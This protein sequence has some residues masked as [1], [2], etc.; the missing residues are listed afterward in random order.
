MEN[1]LEEMVVNVTVNY[2]KYFNN[3]HR[4]MIYSNGVFYSAIKEK[5]L[6]M[7]IWIGEEIIKNKIK[8]GEVDSEYYGL[9]IV[10]KNDDCIRLIQDHYDGTRILIMN[11]SNFNKFVGNLQK[12][13]IFI[14]NEK[15]RKEELLKKY[16]I[17]KMYR[18]FEERYN[19][20]PVEMS[21]C[22]A[23]G[24]ALADRLITK[25][26]YDLAADYY[27]KLWNYVGD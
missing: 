21:A 4:V 7:L 23:F 1:K 2:E 24:K 25:E 14:E 5:D 3:E 11:M 16:N 22:T 17:S 12:M 20:Y 13:K 26:V 18:E 8:I 10:K 6:N 15:I 27:G 19:K 9:K